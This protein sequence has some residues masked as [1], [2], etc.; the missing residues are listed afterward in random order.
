MFLDSASVPFLFHLLFFPNHPLQAFFSSALTYAKEHKV[1]APQTCVS[2]I[3][4][5]RPVTTQ[6]R[7]EGQNCSTEFKTVGGN[8]ISDYCNDVFSF[9][10]F[11]PQAF[12]NV[13]E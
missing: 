5:L 3:L 11:V 10:V 2:S 13:L 7:F 1:L 4:Q 6:D 8:P 9:R 12:L